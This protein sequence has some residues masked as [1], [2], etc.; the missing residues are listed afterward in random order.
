LKFFKSVLFLLVTF[1]AGVFI[2]LPVVSATDDEEQTVLQYN[3]FNYIINDDDN[4]ITITKYLGEEISPIIPNEIDGKQV[5]VIGQSAFE[6]NLKIKTV[7]IPTGV[8]VISSQAFIFCENLEE[9]SLS[10]TVNEIGSNAFLACTNLK[11][12]T[13]PENVKTIDYGTF[14]YC[15]NLK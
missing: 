5:T 10:E 12:I 6:R 1:I 8:I 7:T 9:I 14:S 15:T 11:S 4:T 3:D 13:I 2:T